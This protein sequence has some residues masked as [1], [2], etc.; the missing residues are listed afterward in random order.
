MGK[1]SG[2][3]SA[4]EDIHK[5]RVEF[6]PMGKTPLPEKISTRY[7]PISPVLELSIPGTEDHS[8]LSS[9][10][11]CPRVRVRSTE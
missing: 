10:L 7:G 5:V 3:V 8:Y 4:G 6:G 1:H 2:A 9:C 11:W